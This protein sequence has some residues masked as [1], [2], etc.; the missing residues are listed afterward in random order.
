MID[1]Y[2]KNSPCDDDLLRKDVCRKKAFNIR[3]CIR[4]IEGVRQ[5][6]NI[7]ENELSQEL[8]NK[9]ETISKS[10]QKIL[11]ESQESG[12]LSELLGWLSGMLGC[13]GLGF[14][15]KDTYQG[16]AWLLV[17]VFCGCASLICGLYRYF[18]KKSKY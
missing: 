3:N 11:E 6:C 4:Y 16:S 18:I 7:W 10:N 5:K 8:I 9:V 2:D 12:R 17:P 14:A 1:H 15:L 13:F